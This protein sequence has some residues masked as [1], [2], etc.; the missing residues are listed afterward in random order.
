[1]TQP[2]KS[3][4]EIEKAYLDMGISR[5]NWK[6]VYV[7]PDPINWPWPRPKPDEHWVLSNN[8]LPPRNVD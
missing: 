4:R 5:E 8:T 1:M 7:A 3:L 6:D 2:P